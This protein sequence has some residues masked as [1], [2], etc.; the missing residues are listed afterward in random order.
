MN[1]ERSVARCGAAFFA[2]EGT[3]VAELEKLGSGE[4][5]PILPPA[6]GSQ[7]VL[8]ANAG[9]L[10]TARGIRPSD[11]CVRFRALPLSVTGGV[12]P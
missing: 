2:T 7:A 12:R 4:M 1:F 10:E 11:P 6:R 8:L 9:P 3:E 5:P